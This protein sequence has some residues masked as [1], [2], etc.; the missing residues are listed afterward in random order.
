MGPSVVPDD[1]TGSAGGHENREIPQGVIEHAGG[2][3]E[4]YEDPAEL[5]IDGLLGKLDSG[6]GNYS[7]SGCV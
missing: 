4:E 3:A 5:V 1:R 2:S 6:E 7:N